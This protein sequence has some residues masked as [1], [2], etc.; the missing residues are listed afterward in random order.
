[1]RRLARRGIVARIPMMGVQLE[2]ALVKPFGRD[3]SAFE[4]QKE[5][6]PGPQQVVQVVDAQRGERIGVEGC[7]LAASEACNQTLLEQPLAR[8]IEHTKLARRADQVGELV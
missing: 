6:K 5:P 3:A 8:F 2:S 4:L 1:M 7:G